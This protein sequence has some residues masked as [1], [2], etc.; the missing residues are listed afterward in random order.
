MASRQV[1]DLVYAEATSIAGGLARR[2]SRRAGPPQKRIGGLI[3]GITD[4]TASTLLFGHAFGHA[5]IGGHADQPA[6]G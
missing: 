3:A 6:R 1:S 5:D 4:R 2:H